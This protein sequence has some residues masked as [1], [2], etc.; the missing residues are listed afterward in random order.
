MKSGK[1]V[2][3][4]GTNS[5]YL[6]DTLLKLRGFDP[7]Y[8][9]FLDDTD[10]SLRLAN[11]G[12][13]AAI[14]PLAEVHHAFAPSSRRTIL[15][16]PTFLGDIGHS[17]AVFLRRHKGISEEELLAR[18]CARERSRLIRHM[19]QGTCEPRDI[20]R[21]MKGLIDGWTAGLDVAL[22]NLKPLEDEHTP[23]KRI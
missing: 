17:A 5:A 9:Y 18:L 16:A 11:A 6:R 23:F 1:A 7:S 21:L 10:L 3:L 15:R 14:A 4:V 19:V 8:A 20:R 12:M 22:P 13:T 2:K